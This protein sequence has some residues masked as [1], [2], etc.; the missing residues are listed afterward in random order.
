VP[1]SRQ[2]TSGG[3]LG[4]QAHRAPLLLERI[5][6]K[7]LWCV[8]AQRGEGRWI[9][10]ADEGPGGAVHPATP[11]DRIEIPALGDCQRP[12]SNKRDAR[13]QQTV[14]RTACR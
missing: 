9:P 7:A 13:E 14:G 3:A 2:A 11:L 1:A 6:I 4:L 8:S 12:A 10:L 5:E